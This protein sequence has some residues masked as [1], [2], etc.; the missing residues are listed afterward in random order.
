MVCPDVAKI[1]NMYIKDMQFLERIEMLGVGATDLIKASN[2]KELDRAGT[3]T[4]TTVLSAEYWDH[5]WVQESRAIAMR[6]EY[7]F[8]IW[9][10]RNKLWETKEKS[11]IP[12]VLEFILRNSLYLAATQVAYNYVK[13]RDYFH[14][15][16]L[17]M[18]GTLMRYHNW[19]E[20]DAEEES[21][22]LHLGF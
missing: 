9:E 22:L 3:H 15:H 17:D 2:K 1:I 21:P 14:M 7:L 19:N 18:Y 20:P 4:M 11:K 8:H 10:A 6:V 5:T 12:G 16:S 13:D